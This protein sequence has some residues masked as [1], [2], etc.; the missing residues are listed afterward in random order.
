MFGLPRSTATPV[1][2]VPAARPPEPAP[3]PSGKGWIVA[4]AIA[5]AVIIAW[6][7]LR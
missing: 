2:G 5:S 4:A 6:L 1:P 7:L 3:R